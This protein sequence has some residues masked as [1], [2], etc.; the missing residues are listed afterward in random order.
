[1]DDL[2][3]GPRVKRLRV[4]RGMTQ[5]QL[6]DGLSMS[7]PWVKGFEGGTIQA[8]PKFGLLRRLA[9]VLTVPLHALVDDADPP[10]TTTVDD[11]RAALLAP[12]P[13]D[14]SARVDVA[15]EAAYG[16]L[17]FQAGRWRD[18]VATLPRLIS[19]ARAVEGGVGDPRALRQLADVCH[20]AAITLTKLG[21][22]AGGWAAGHEAVLRAEAAQDPLEIALSAQSAI[23]AATAAARPD[24]G[25][26]LAHRVIDSAG[27][28]LV[29]RGEDGVS[30]LG[31]VYLKGAYAAAASDDA[32]GAAI[33]ID[34]GRRA[35]A[36]LAPDANHCLTSFNV[37]NV[38]IYEA[39]I[40]GDLGEYDRA[41]DVATRIPPEAFAGLSRERR[42]HHLVDTARSAQGAGRPDSALSLLLQAE[43]DDPQ[44][45]RTWALSRSV[46]IA[47]L[48]GRQP[49]DGRGLHGLA[50]RA[51]VAG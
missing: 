12:T 39:S 31:M 28:D 4:A 46:I 33:M 50:V 36:R 26:D 34:E 22:T 3:I 11:V 29:R 16:H 44:N 41:L 2:G 35:A 43:R 23:Y 8:D 49:A 13:H 42:I 25:L 19:A 18:V 45:I 27:A 51:G 5:Q 15:Q 40:L 38:L 30:A 17:A 32:D 24:V 1:M 9:A 48:S 21:D 47:L 14:E 20:L 7:L 6:A 10:E 37:T